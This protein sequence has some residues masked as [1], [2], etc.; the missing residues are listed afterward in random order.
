MTH[1]EV[2][3]EDDNAEVDECVWSRDQVSL[4]V[5]DENDGS[6]NWGFGVAEM[7]LKMF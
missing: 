7:K 6:N 1:L 2:D 4:F 5:Q 3:Q